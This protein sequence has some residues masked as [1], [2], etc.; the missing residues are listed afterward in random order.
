MRFLPWRKNSK[1][2]NAE[3]RLYE[4][5]ISVWCDFVLQKNI[6]RIL[7][8]DSHVK[9]WHRG[10]R[11]RSVVRKH[12]ACSCRESDIFI[13]S[14]QQA[15]CSALLRDFE[16]CSATESICT[17]ALSGKIIGSSPIMTQGGAGAWCKL[18][19]CFVAFAPRNDGFV[20][21]WL[22]VAKNLS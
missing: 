13:V 9:Q 19:D 4:K 7:R 18:L 1:P 2:Q 16:P 3:A 11:A 10:E 15:A 17:W 20:K 5:Y 6:F 22:R 14:I 8:K 12:P 21:Y